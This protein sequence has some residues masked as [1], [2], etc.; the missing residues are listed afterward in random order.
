MLA[1]VPVGWEGTVPRSTEAASLCWKRTS[2]S[3][4]VVSQRRMHDSGVWR[5][6]DLRAEGR[7]RNANHARVPSSLRLVLGWEARLDVS[8][9]E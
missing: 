2:L 5:C 3:G 9:G 6:K 8:A 1:G 7:R 4:A